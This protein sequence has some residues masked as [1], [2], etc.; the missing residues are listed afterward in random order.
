LPTNAEFGVSVFSAMAAT[1]PAAA[2]AYVVA[3]IVASAVSYVVVAVVNTNAEL[4]VGCFL[5]LLLLGLLL[6]W[7]M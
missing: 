7:L 4:G 1:W 2:M 5:Q 3:P 6:Q